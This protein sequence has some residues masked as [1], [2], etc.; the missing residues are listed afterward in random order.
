MKKKIFALVLCVALL[1]VAIVG[2]TLAYF[3][4]TKAQTNTFTA[5]NVAIKLDEA[6][7]ESDA[8]GNLV[9]KGN[10]RT[11]EA[12]TY[13][14][15][16]GMTVA[17][18][19]TIT[20]TGTEDAYIAAKITVTGD[21]ELLTLYGQDNT[22]WKG[23]DVNKMLSGGLIGATGTTTSWNGLY[24]Y[25]SEDCF[26]YQD[27]SGADNG[28]WVIYV[29]MK[30]AVAKDGKV[31]LFTTLSVDKTFNN[32]EMAILNEAQVKVDAYAAQEHGFDDCFEA[33][34]TAFATDFHFATTP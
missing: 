1:A 14:L 17:K 33:M 2:G 15:Y 34:T 6:V 21:A 29:F 28:V 24:G 22:D 30:D 32:D 25:E 23:L 31:V 27:A 4:D 18:D 11:T 26:V 16:P 20:V 9:A 3:T 7:V 12:Q 8:N 13:K 10:D 19:P 5:G